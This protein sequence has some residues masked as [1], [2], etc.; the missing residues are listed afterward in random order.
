MVLQPDR[1]EVND[2]RRFGVMILCFWI[3]LDGLLHYHCCALRKQVAALSVQLATTNDL[4]LLV[5]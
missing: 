2:C 4:L 3:W 1:V 5:C